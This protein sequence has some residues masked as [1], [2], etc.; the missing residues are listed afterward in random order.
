MAGNDAALVVMNPRRIPEVLDALDALV[1]VDVCYLTGFTELE[2]MKPMSE[3]LVS[4]P[5]AAIVADDVVVTQKAL[6]NVLAFARENPSACTTG[7]CNLAETEDRADFANVC[8][9]PLADAQP[10]AYSYHFIRLQDLAHRGPRPVTFAG[11]CLTTMHKA[12]WDRFPFAVYTDGH[13]GWAS[14]YHLSYRLGQAGIPIWAVG[15]SCRHLKTV[16]NQ[17]DRSPERRL[18]LGARTISW[19]HQ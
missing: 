10:N 3:A 1:G 19:R 17:R 9:L 4:R 14:D 6:D 15:P 13:T 2:L 8:S 18:H 5:I 12:M 16:W 11:M 7:Y